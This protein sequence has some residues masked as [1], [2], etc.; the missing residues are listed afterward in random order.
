MKGTTMIEKSIKLALSCAT[1]A[2]AAGIF[3]QQAKAESGSATW[4]G[5][6]GGV[7]HWRGHGD[8]GHYRGT[9]V[10]ETPDG[11]TYRRVTTVRRGPYGVHASRRW[12]G[13]NGN[14]AYVYG[15]VR[16]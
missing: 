10:L 8:A 16:Y 7:V 12:I 6:N 15:G 14:A 13:P 3:S 9:L 5:P 4:V 1:L 11:R 2:L